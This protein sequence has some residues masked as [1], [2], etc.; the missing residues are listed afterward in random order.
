MSYSHMVYLGCYLHTKNEKAND[1]IQEKLSKTEVDLVMDSYWEL[2]GKYHKEIN[3]TV[4]VPMNSD[5][6]IR[7]EPRY[8]DDYV[9]EL[10]IDQIQ[11]KAKFIRSNH[12]LNSGIGLLMRK[13]F[14][15]IEI[16]YGIINYT[17]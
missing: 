15:D 12:W 9:I 16:K 3:G 6:G 5:S 4:F 1:V 13:C 10:N 2:S 14:P 7:I 11:E 8:E 17:T